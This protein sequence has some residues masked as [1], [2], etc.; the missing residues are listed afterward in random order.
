MPPRPPK[1]K[2]KAAPASAS[3]QVRSLE[4][5]L[6]RE[7]PAHV[8]REKRGGAGGAC[9]SRPKSKADAARARILE[10]YHKVKFFERRKVERRIAHLKKQLE[11]RPKAQPSCGSSCRRGARATSSTCSTSAAQEV[12]LALPGGGHR[13]RL[14]RK[15]ARAHPRGDRPARGGG[16]AARARRRRRRRRGRGGAR[17]GGRRAGGGRFLRGGRGRGRR[18]E[19]AVDEAPPVEAE[20]RPKIGGKRPKASAK[21]KRARRPEAG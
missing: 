11:R 7:L 21:P 17:G 18:D 1:A 16:H 20:R 14:R 15:A 4:R 19:D 2:A 6:K 12:P 3:K 13:R 5:L 10:K 8:R 9:S